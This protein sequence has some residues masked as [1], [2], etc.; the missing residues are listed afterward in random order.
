MPR[1]CWSRLSVDEISGPIGNAEQ[2][3]L[4]TLLIPRT[5]AVGVRFSFD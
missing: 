4:G 2:F 1:V 3:N 5:F